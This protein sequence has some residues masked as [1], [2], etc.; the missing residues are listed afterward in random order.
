MSFKKSL[1]LGVTLGVSSLVPAGAVT[2]SLDGFMSYQPTSAFDAAT[3]DASA[4]DKLVVVVTGEHN[5]GGNT[6]GDISGITYDGTPLVQA[7]NR[8]PIDSSNITAADIWYLDNPGSFHVSGVLDATVVG[9]G[10]NYVYTV[11]ALSGTAPGVGATAVS[12]AN[13]KSVSLNALGSDSF[14]VASHGMG[15]DGNTAN[16]LS[17]GADAPASQIAALEAGNNWAG[18]V[19]SFTNGVAP[20]AATYSF[21]GGSAGGNV[22]IAAEFQA[23]PEPS[24][25][26]FLGIGALAL[27]RRRRQDR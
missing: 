19:V 7:V 6:S 9:N 5:F 26:A 2:I 12:A 14:V 21:T 18:H 11:I 17:V 22:T 16:V 23:I 13:S 15:G 20:G 8:Q 3:F 25:L 27:L 10:N 4:S 1:L 24:S